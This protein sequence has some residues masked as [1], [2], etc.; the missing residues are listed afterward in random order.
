MG[1][2]YNC[3]CN[4]AIATVQRGLFRC[5]RSEFW[6]LQPIGVFLNSRKELQATGMSRS[7]WGPWQ[8][9]T[10]NDGCSTYGW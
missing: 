4:K 3:L 1:S 9:A 10:Q 7:S 2:A 6:P 5:K 8:T